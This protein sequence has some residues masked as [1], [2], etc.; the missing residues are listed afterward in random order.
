MKEKFIIQGGK[1]LEGEIEVRGAKNSAGPVLAAT[2]LTDEECIID[3]LPKISDILNLI[4]I[5][6]DIGKQVEWLGDRKVRITGDGFDPSKID[7]E[8]VSKSRVSVLLMG[9][10]LPRVREFKMS[11]PGGDKIGL[12]PIN[13]H[14]DALKQ[15]GAEIQ[16]DGDF[17][18]IK[19]SKLKG[20]EIILP[21]FSVTATENLLMASVLAE[22]TTVI[23]TAALEP[24][25]Q[26]L[27]VMLNNMGADIQQGAHVFTIKGVNKL[28]G[29]E[30]R[31][32]PDTN[33]AGTFLAMGAAAG[34]KVI[35]KDMIP[36]HLDLF[37]LKLKEMGVEVTIN[38]SCIQVSKPD[39]FNPVRIQAL[40]YPGFPT[41][42]LPL[43]IPVLTQAQGKSMIHDPLYEN[44]LN[45]VHQLR[46]MGADVEIVDP[47]RAFVFGRTELRG[48]SIESGDIRAGASLIVAG[49]M[50]KGESKLKNISQIDRGYEEI[51]K[52]L[53][54][55]GA[56]IKRICL[57]QK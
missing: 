37:L 40:P 32:I 57:S 33:E 1:E 26:D 13:V 7:F 20:A 12:R 56:D 35:V 43:I 38:D 41:D 42:L 51:E 30:H 4:D 55:I 17:Y 34:K 53:Q 31:I 24:H 3:N 2:L 16:E 29:V 10:L 46:K 15:L 39:K 18:Y 14:L 9:P 36:E 22:G 52:R 50:A 44:R 5:L 23:K 47:H 11:R 21:E 28:K 45:Y 27:A 6:Q 19:C 48:V 25:V 8:K 54:N 49:L